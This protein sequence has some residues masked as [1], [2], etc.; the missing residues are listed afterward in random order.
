[1]GG[2]HR[3]ATLRHTGGLRLSRQQ[4]GRAHQIAV[5]AA[6]EQSAAHTTEKPWSV[7]EHGLIATE[8]NERNRLKGGSPAVLVKA[9]RKV[10]AKRRTR[11]P[12]CMTRE[13]G[14]YSK[15]LEHR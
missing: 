13:C 5:D 15:V 6:T 10:A 14:T 3:P 7:A 11:P 12:S 9:Q 2:A 8:Q 1:M 4:A